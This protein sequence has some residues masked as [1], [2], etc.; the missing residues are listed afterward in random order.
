MRGRVTSRRG[1]VLTEAVL[2]LPLFMVVLLLVL[3]GI[4]LMVE[5]LVSTYALFMGVRVASVATEH[6][7]ARAQRQAAQIL[8][9]SLRYQRW[10][11]PWRVYHVPQPRIAV[12]SGDNGLP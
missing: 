1:S 2:A 4:T 3:G 5:K 6:A 10:T 7:T 9:Q 12:T 8:P 11:A